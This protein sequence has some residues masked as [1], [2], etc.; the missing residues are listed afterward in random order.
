MKTYH[1]AAKAWEISSRRAGQCTPFSLAQLAPA[2]LLQRTEN[3]GCD[4]RALQIE[5][6]MAEQFG[7]TAD[8]AVASL[9]KHHLQQGAVGVVLPVFAAFAVPCS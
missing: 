9:T 8:L 3:D 4:R 2:T 6:W 7:H 1:A 5:H